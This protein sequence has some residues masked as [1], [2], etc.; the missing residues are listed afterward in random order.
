MLFIIGIT[1]PFDIRDL[2]FDPASYKTIP[3]L[4]GIKGAKVVASLLVGSTVLG[5]AYL[6]TNNNIGLIG[7]VSQIIVVAITLVVIRN[8]KPQRPELY[9]TGL[10]DGLIILSG[11]LLI[12]TESYI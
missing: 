3:Q 5:W 12:P 8:T 9:F 11:I 7:L 10:I 4:F 2:S 6:Y 1:I